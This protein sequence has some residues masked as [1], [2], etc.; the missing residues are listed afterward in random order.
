MKK[1]RD[2]VGEDRSGGVGSKKRSQRK[3]MAVSNL[4]KKV[5]KPSAWSVQYQEPTPLSN[6]VPS[7][8]VSACRSS[9]PPQ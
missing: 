4:L 5:F 3:K 6:P 1:R 2:V 8:Q 7:C 9:L